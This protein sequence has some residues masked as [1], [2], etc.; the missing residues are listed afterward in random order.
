MGCGAVIRAVFYHL[1]YI[2]VRG[3]W[4]FSPHLLFS[5]FDALTLSL[6]VMLSFDF[7]IVSIDG[8]RAFSS[9]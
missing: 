3:D 8:K 1:L 9:S 7:F 2:V 5:S 4:D 6:L